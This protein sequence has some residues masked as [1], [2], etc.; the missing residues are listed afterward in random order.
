MLRR[1]SD[2]IVT[3]FLRRVMTS[4]MIIKLWL[5]YYLSMNDYESGF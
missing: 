5:L 4:E 1:R 3:L 2:I